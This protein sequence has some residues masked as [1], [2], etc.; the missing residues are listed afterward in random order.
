MAQDGGSRLAESETLSLIASWANQVLDDV[1]AEAAA[2]QGLVL[3]EDANDVPAKRVRGYLLRQLGRVHQECN[4][5]EAALR[6]LEQARHL[7]EAHGT[8]RDLALTLHELGRVHHA[9]NE[10]EQALAYLEQA[11][12]LKE[13]HGT[14]R[15]IAITLYRLAFVRYDRREYDQALLDI[16]RALEIERSLQTEDIDKPEALERRILEAMCAQEIVGEG[17]E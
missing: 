12:H 1:R 10:L 2:N 7:V 17:G 9:R 14:L 3:I 16:R 11:Y 13:A 6:Y 4:E 8:P 5:L 15:S